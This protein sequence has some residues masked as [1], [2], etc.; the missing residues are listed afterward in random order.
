[1]S[2]DSFGECVYCGATKQVDLFEFDPQ[3]RF[4]CAGCGPDWLP[5]TDAAEMPEPDEGMNTTERPSLT[6]LEGGLAKD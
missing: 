1:M 3:G 6:L 5:R 4:C 2:S